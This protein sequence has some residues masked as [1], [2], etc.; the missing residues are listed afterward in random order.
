MPIKI[1]SFIR[2][3]ERDDLDTMVRWMQ[4]PDFQHFLYGDPARSPRRI[5]ASIINMLS[6]T[7]TNVMPGAIYL[8]IESPDRGPL[9]MVLLKGVS[10]RN[11]NCSIDLYMARD[12]RSSMEAGAGMVRA[13]DYCFEELN[14]HR[15]S[16]MI[17][18]FNRPS[19]RLI[20]RCGAVRE[21]TLEE[22][23]LRDGEYH[24][25]YGYGLL[26]HEWAAFKSKNKAAQAFSLEKMVAALRDKDDS[27]GD[28]PE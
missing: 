15:I 6:R 9:G 16:A 22:H 27:G 5:R 28:P 4:D 20:E 10:W 14:L 7:S 21:L 11:R 26:A 12:V 23:V 24:T 2:R 17:Y 25:M 1:T 13:I 8:V 18:A 19:W 3:A